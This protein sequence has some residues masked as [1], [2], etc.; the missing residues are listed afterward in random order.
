MTIKVNRKQVVQ[1]IESIVV[2][3]GGNFHNIVV[4]KASPSGKIRLGVD[5]GGIQAYL[6]TKAEA[7]EVATAL[8]TFAN[9]VA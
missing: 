8:T 3:R 4:D 2:S 5:K 6:F 7:K 1:P 9:E